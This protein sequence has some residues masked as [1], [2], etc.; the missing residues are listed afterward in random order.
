MI[1]S[2]MIIL[3]IIAF[4][5]VLF[6]FLKRHS[7]ISPF[8]MA[9]IIERF[10]D[11]KSTDWEWD[12]FISSPVSDH[13]LDKIRIRCSQLDKEF[14]PLKLGEYTNEKGIEILRQYVRY[15][16]GQKNK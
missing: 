14:P 16:R 13:S 11:G 6:I 15:L 5:V 8:D 10:I 3:G 7:R 1:I 4:F 12:D 9:N 2:C